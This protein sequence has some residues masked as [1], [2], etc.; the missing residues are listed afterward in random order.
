MSVSLKIDNFGSINVKQITRI[1]ADANAGD[2]QVSV[3]S[4]E[5]Y[6]PGDFIVLGPRGTDL[7]EPLTIL[8]IVDNTTIQFS[9]TLR[10]HHDQYDNVTSL[11][12]DQIQIYISPNVD[13][14]QPD[15]TTFMTVGVPFN[16]TV[17]ESS[18]AFNDNT[19]G[20]NWYKFAYYNSVTQIQTDLSNSFA[21][22][23]GVVQYSSTD[24]VRWAA[25]YGN[26]MWITDAQIDTKRKQ[27]QAHIDGVLQSA[28]TVPFPSPVNATIE[29]ICTQL[30]AAYVQ[31]DD[32]GIFSSG[33]AKDGEAREKRAEAM[34]QAVNA[35]D[36]IIVDYNGDNIALPGADSTQG[37]PTSDENDYSDNG[38]NRIFDMSKIY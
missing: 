35:R 17:Y 38:N 22:R 25:G 20:D 8:T 27:A 3:D 13:N 18:T 30:T 34:L 10:L 5:G 1:T 29:K 7:A 19:P 26:N 33:N 9:T 4:T 11:F 6:N 16:I 14:T 32:Y 2:Q 21:A 23:S 28:Y 37:Y 24:D 12:G 31:Q 15:D 36:E